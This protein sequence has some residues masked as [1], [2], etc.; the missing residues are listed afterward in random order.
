[1]KYNSLFSIPYR[2]TTFLPTLLL[3][4]FVWNFPSVMSTYAW[5]TCDNSSTFT[6]GSTYS[7]DLNLV[8]N[9]LY[10]NAPKSSGFNTS[11]HGQSPSKVYGLLQCTRNVSAERCSKCVVEANKTIHDL[12]PND[13]GG[14]I[15]LDDCFMRYQ[16][17]NFISRLDTNKIILLNTMDISKS[18]DAFENTTSSLLSN[19]SD[20]ACIPA[21]KGVAAGTA[22]YN[23]TGILYG[24]VQCCRDISTE[25]CR[26]CLSKARANLSNCCSTKQGAQ[27][28]S[29]SCRARYEIYPILDSQQSPSPLPSPSPSPEESVHPTT[30]TPEKKSSKTLPIVLGLVGGIILVLFICLVVFRQRVK[31]L[32]FKGP[33]TIATPTQE[34]HGFSPQPAFMGEQNLVFSLQALVEATDNFND[35][36]KLG[37]GGF[38]A[39]YKG[40][41]SDGNEIAVKKLSA[42]S[43]QGKKEFMNEVKLVANVQ[44]RNLARLLGCCVEGN[45]RLL[46]YD[47]F[48]NKSLDTFLFDVE[49][50]KELDWE[51]RYNIIIGIARGLLYLHQESQLRIIHRDI[52]ANN[53]LLDHKLNPKIA[54]FGLAKLFPEDK[55]HIHTRVAGTY[56]Y[57][58]PEYAMRGQLSVKVDV[59]SFG[60]VLLE[61]IS[62]RKNND[63]HLP[64]DMQHLVEWAWKLFQ[65]GNALNMADSEASGVSEEEALRCIH[66]GLLCV[67]ANA[68]F[69]PVMSDVITML[70]SSSVTLPNPSKPAFVSTGHSHSLKPEPMSMSSWGNDE[71]KIVTTS[72]ISGAT[73]TSSSG[74]RS[75][76]EASITEVEAR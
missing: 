25:D 5:H 33:V 70:S 63:N 48:P 32:I 74:I 13:I 11:S 16:N 29:A 17:Y 19:L 53:I 44:H 28:L 7:T 26:T 18:R 57:M 67:Q 52:K 62:G 23:A 59:Y 14:K 21:N 36:N 40:I 51:K 61:I 30:S 10:L 66:V 3:L 27:F 39:V 45:E 24:L 20:T 8:I 38:G 42:K 6:N 49:K 34:M 46:V 72:Q 47:Y 73:T 65:G 2:G 41:T 22:K 12:C 50:R 43:K 68:T 15:W 60:V 54:D 4:L 69:R 35:N 64:Y 75:V 1:M 76:N 37:Q 71:D 55:T 9:D 56:G 31:S 58:P